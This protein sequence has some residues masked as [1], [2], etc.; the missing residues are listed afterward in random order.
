MKRSYPGEGEKGYRNQGQGGEPMPL[1]R[2]TRGALQNT[3][4]QPLDSYPP[5]YGPQTSFSEPISQPQ[6]AQP[7]IVAAPPKSAS[8]RLTPEQMLDKNNPKREPW[9]ITNSQLRDVN[10]GRDLT[11]PESWIKAR[12]QRILSNKK[13]SQDEKLTRL[14]G[15]IGQEQAIDILTSPQSSPTPPQESITREDIPAQIDTI[16][17]TVSI[18]AN[19]PP[20]PIATLQPTTTSEPGKIVRMAVGEDMERDEATAFL[21]PLPPTGHTHKETTQ[22][23]NTPV[24]TPSRPRVTNQTSVWQPYPRNG[25][26]KGVTSS[27]IIAA[28]VAREQQIAQAKGLSYDQQPNLSSVDLRQYGQIAPKRP[29]PRRRV[30]FSVPDGKPYTSTYLD[31]A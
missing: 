13:L 3:F 4:H 11:I 19:Q 26:L 7:E 21:L 5:T 2:N 12:V 16:D 10:D 17:Q 14:I 9:P 22:V 28:E 25:K 8:T 24:T 31:K 20:M 30:V 15:L 27:D 18:S 1:G 23:I 6:H 29:E